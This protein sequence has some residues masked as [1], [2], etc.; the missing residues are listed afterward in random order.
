MIDSVKDYSHVIMD[1]AY[2]SSD[3]YEYTFDNTQCSQIIDTNR[4]RRI[5]YSRLSHSRMEGIR[6][7]REE[8]SRYSFRWEIE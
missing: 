3:I 1:A 7:R 2:D 4:W 8:A 6:N 5:A